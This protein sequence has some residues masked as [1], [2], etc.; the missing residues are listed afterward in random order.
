M[1]CNVC[2]KTITLGFER[3]HRECFS[4][5][6]QSSAPEV[7]PDDFPA[8]EANKR[9]GERYGIDWEYKSKSKP[10]L[11]SGGVF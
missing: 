2:G 9:Y 4:Q 10:Y 8:D 1:K 11:Y 7:V 6:Q 5:V 3:E